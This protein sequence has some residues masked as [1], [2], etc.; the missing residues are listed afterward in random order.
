[1]ACAIAGPTRSVVRR[2]LPLDFEGASDSVTTTASALSIEQG[3]SRT[4][5]R[6]PFGG[7]RM[8]DGEGDGEGENDSDGAEEILEVMEARRS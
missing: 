3:T 5:L 2:P 1:M 7:E 4:R 6:E 8:G